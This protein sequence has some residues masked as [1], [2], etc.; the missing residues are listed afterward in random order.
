MFTGIHGPADDFMWGRVDFQRMMAQ[1]AM[2]VFFMSHGINPDFA[3]FGDPERN[4]VRLVWNP[5]PVLAGE[6]YAEIRDDQLRRWWNRGYRRFVFFNE[7][8]LT[9]EHTHSS[10][11]MGI[12][13]H[14]EEQFA[15]Y[16]RHCLEQARHDFPGIKLYTTPMSTFH[17]FD[18]GKWYHAM[19]RQV[20]GLVDGWCMHAYTGINDDA[21]AAAI[22]IANQIRDVRREFRLTIPL[23]VSEASVNRGRNAAQKAQVAHLLPQKLAGEPGIEGIFWFAADWNP[24]FDENREGWFRTGIAEA[25]LR[26]KALAPG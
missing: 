8:Q 4:M 6:A 14:S 22:D 25:Y 24:R 23:V 26:I 21:H 19:W 17:L 1:L 20:R 7:P 12:A 16:L 3:H 5:R 11:G 15:L 18:P 10:E 9:T 13:W 2:P